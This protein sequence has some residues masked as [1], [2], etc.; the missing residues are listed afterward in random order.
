MLS[1]M[2]DRYA[3]AVRARRAELR[4]SYQQLVGSHRVELRA[5]LALSRIETAA[6]AGVAW[7]RLAREIRAYVDGGDRAG[8]ARLP[9]LVAA[10]IEAVTET[11]LANWAADLRP[12][13]RRI[14]GVR[15]LPVDRAWPVI[16]RPR[17]PAPVPAMPEPV[18]GSPLLGAVDGAAMWRLM[19][20]PLGVVPLLGLPVIGGLALAP[21][22]A[23]AGVVGVAVAIRSRRVALERVA[24]RRCTE[25]VLATGRAALDAE[26]GRLLLELERVAGAELDH[27][28]ARRRDAIAAEL[29]CLGSSAEQASGG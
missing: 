28:A 19:L 18:R 23:C 1:A 3:D 12:G 2:P 20:L 7:A 22:V 10:A 14:A 6:A 11:V 4:A 5:E 9:V 26:I 27:A 24:L 8:R 13:L 15:A 17:R 25:E 16:P 29:G 21:L